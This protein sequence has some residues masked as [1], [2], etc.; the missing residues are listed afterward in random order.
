M[1]KNDGHFSQNSMDRGQNE[2]GNLGVEIQKGL[3]TDGVD[4]VVSPIIRWENNEKTMSS[5]NGAISGTKVD[6]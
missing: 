1:S 5:Q 4:D 2:D 3:L 6:L